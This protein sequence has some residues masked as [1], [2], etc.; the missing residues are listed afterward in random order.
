M[1]SR[2]IACLEFVALMA[3]GCGADEAE[4]SPEERLQGSW[5]AEDATGFDCGILFV[6]KDNSTYEYDTL[7]SL[8]GGGI[9]A[10]GWVGDFEYDGERL[11]LSATH[12][13]CV[14]GE[15]SSDVFE[16]HVGGDDLMIVAPGATFYLNRVP[17]GDDVQGPGVTISH[18]CYADD[19][20][21]TPGELTEL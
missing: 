20:A 4:K 12:S 21:F 9:G 18:G 6:F 7:C 1:T 13:T 3:A 2:A 5:Y 14:N 16:A 19:G 17:E 11:T 15:P 8:E 10:E